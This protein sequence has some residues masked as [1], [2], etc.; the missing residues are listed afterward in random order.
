MAISP[1]ELFLIKY[2][3]SAKRKR[4][5]II[6]FA[7]TLLLEPVNFNI[8]IAENKIEIDAIVSKITSIFTQ[9]KKNEIAPKTDYLFN[10]LS[11]IQI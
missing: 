4:K 5:Y 8:E 9:I 10:G 6:Y 11:L 1:I 2:S 3:E 7:I